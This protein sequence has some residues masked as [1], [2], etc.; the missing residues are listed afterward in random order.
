MDFP[1]DIAFRHLD[2]S[3]A[4]ETLIRDRA[5][6][7]ARMN[8]RIVSMHVVVDAPQNHA[9]TG[10]LYTVSLDIS[11]PGREIVVNRQGPHAHADAY[12]AVRDAFAAAERQMRKAER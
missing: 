7:L 10:H 11:I 3:E 8:G 12:M 5:S 9:Q 6:K 2:H 4:L 1:L